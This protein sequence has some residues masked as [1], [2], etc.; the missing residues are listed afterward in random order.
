MTTKTKKVALKPK[1]I[2]AARIAAFLLIPFTLLQFQA[3]NDDD[4][5]EPEN[6]EELITTLI[7]TFTN[8][9]DPND[10]VE[11]KFQDLDGDG[12]D[13]PVI[14]NPTL[15]NGATY[16]AEIEVLNESVS[17]TEDITEEVEE[18]GE[19]HQFFFASSNASLLSFS[20]LD[21]DNSG[22]PIG[23]STEWVVNEAGTATFRVTLRHEPDKNAEGVS[24]G[25]ITNA[26]GETDIEVDFDL[27]IE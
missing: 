15:T 27:T 3:C 1:F 18:E 8:V 14:T 25:D 22:N 17:P 4:D 21:E 5:P 6:E 10:E 24:E 16:R 23:I 20:Y 7:M 26:G 19:E 11:A 2:K 12:G 13:A 9:D